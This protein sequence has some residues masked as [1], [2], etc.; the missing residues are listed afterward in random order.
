VESPRIILKAIISTTVSLGSNESR[1]SGLTFVVGCMEELYQG[2]P[3]SLPAIEATSKVNWKRLLPVDSCVE[4]TVV[5]CGANIAKVA[6]VG[7]DIKL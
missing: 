3:I 4:L 1:N 7:I 5:E 6:V 2:K